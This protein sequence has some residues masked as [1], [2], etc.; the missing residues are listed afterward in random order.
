MKKGKGKEEGD[1]FCRILISDVLVCNNIG[2]KREPS[3]PADNMVDGNQYK[4]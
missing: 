2:S 1:N 3:W 4:R